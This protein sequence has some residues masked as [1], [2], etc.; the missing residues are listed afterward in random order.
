MQT[1]SVVHPAYLTVILT[2]QEVLFAGEGTAIACTCC[3]N[4]GI[5]VEHHEEPLSLSGIGIVHTSI[6]SI[7]C[8][9]GSYLFRCTGDIRQFTVTQFRGVIDLIFE[10]DVIDCFQ[11]YLR[12]DVIGIAARI[13][14]TLRQARVVIELCVGHLCPG[15]VFLLQ[16]C[17]GL[18]V[19][20]AGHSTTCRQRVAHLVFTELSGN[21]LIQYH[22]LQPVVLQDSIPGHSS[23]CLINGM[24]VIFT[25]NGS[26]HEFYT[27]WSC[28]TT[29]HTIDLSRHHFIARHTDLVFR[30]VSRSPGTTSCQSRCCTRT[31][32]CTRCEVIG[33]CCHQ[34][35]PTA[36]FIA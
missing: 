10:I 27:I 15:I 30:V 26:L 3:C 28:T 18:K 20:G 22:R 32:C 17:A 8:Y 35:R 11:S 1:V 31:G 19:V 5:G 16:F 23:R 36:Q 12:I 2:A 9:I 25:A 6:G 21:D 14:Y 29:T 33:T 34:H 4:S 13:I 7:V 24:V